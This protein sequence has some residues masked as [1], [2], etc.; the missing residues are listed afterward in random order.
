MAHS[1]RRRARLGSLV[2]KRGRRVSVKDIVISGLFLTLPVI[3]AAGQWPQFRGPEAGVAIDDPTLPETWSETDG[4]VWTTEIPGQGWS[5]PIV[6][7][8]HVF[9]TTAISSG[10]EPVPRAGFADPT[11]D[12]GRMQST[13][14]HRWVVYDLD[15]RTGNVRWE[16][17]LHTGLAP[18]MRH[19]RNSYATE[20]PVTDGE[21]VYVCF[22]TIGLLAALDLHGTPVWTKQIGVFESARGWGMAGSPVLH[23]DRLYIVND[24]DA[25]SFI[26]AFDTRTGDEVWRDTREEV[27][28]W[29][30]PVVWEHEQRTEIVTA[31]ER[32]VRSYDLSGALLWELGGMSQY[33]PIPTPFVRHGLVYISSGHPGS[34][35]RP[36]F[37]VRPGA[38][39]DISLTPGETSNQYVAWSR[40]RLG[41]YQTSGLVYGDY[42]YTLLDRGFLLCH[43]ARTGAEVYGRHRIE[44]GSSFAASPWAY[45]GKLFAL[46]EDGDTYVIQAGPEFKLLGK[47]SLNEMALATPAIAHGSLF[48]RTQS[49]LYRIS[50]EAQP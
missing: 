7:G 50:K 33:G 1:L 23:E 17:E 40:P 19:I 45:N 18:M 48:I 15:V 10:T 38:S 42:L 39:G 37:A 11:P 6:W 46:S 43:D 4:V 26:A 41:S 13:A 28:S 8:D 9:V 32:K 16:R 31:G 30:T 12:Y 35:R 2:P 34:P 36:V 47:N 27:E 3:A 49:R 44:V 5:S 21:L 24:N 22:G 25:Q 14:A 29:S 20:T